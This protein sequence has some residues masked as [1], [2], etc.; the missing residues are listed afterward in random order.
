[1]ESE[2]LRMPDRPVLTPEIH[3]QQIDAFRKIR[4]QYEI[5]ARAL[6]RVL[7]HACRFSFPDALV[8]SRAKTVSSFAEKV[9]RKF[10]KYPN[11]VEQLKDFC[12]ARVIVQTLEQVR[13]VRSFIEA[14]FEILESE[15]KGLLLSTDKFGYRDMHYVVCLQTDRAIRLGFTEDEL[16]EIGTRCAE[17]QVR[18]WLEHAWADTL[19][20]RI[21]KNELKLSPDS[22]RT[23]ALLAALMEEGDRNFNVLA[24]DLDGLIAN[25]TALASKTEVQKEIEIQQLILDQELEEGKRPG[26]ALKLARLVGACGDHQRVVE[27]LKGYADTRDGN[28][29]DLLLELGRSICSLERGKPASPEYGRGVTFLREAARICE[30]PQ[31]ASVPH[32][33][34]RQSRHARAVALLG[35]AMTAINGGDPEARQ[36]FR[37]AHELEPAD[38]YYL[39]TMLGFELRFE[40]RSGLP[41]SMATT[42]QEAVRICREHAAAGIELPAAY[43]SAGR[44]SLLL[45][46]GYEALGYY[47]L[48]MRYCLSGINCV[49]ADALAEEKRWI[50]A[51]HPGVEVSQESRR[52]LDLFDLGERTPGDAN[53]PKQT[54]NWRHPV[55]ILTGGAVSLQHELIGKTKE[56][57]EKSCG[58][59]GGTI[60]S[61]GTTAGVPGCIGDVAREL[62]GK[63]HKQ[64]KLIGYRPALLPRAQAAHLSYDEIVEIG[65]NFLPDQ[66][67]RNWADLVDGGVRP[68][69]VLVLGIGGG[70]LSLVEYQVALTLGAQVGILNGTGGTADVLIADPLWSGLPNLYRL[71]FDHATVRAFVIRG[72]HDLPAD[73]QLQMAQFFHAKYVAGGSNRLPPNMR[74][75][76]KLERTYIEANREQAR[77]SVE[78][79]KAAGFDVIKSG[80]IEPV[81]PNFTAEEV[82][83]MAELEHGRWNV[84]RLRNGWRYGKVKDEPQR[85]HDCLVSWEELPAHIKTYDQE[86]V[87]VFPEALAQAGLA[88]RRRE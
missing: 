1:M 19:H 14:N 8:Q 82:E 56:L 85:I 72:D 64:F 3:R 83:C 25:Y 22:L 16:T 29:C 73:L 59:F 12:G 48:G 74:P 75:W 18:T 41:P 70:A 53:G 52:I 42:I 69:D 4:P 62:S 54:V 81:W 6:K 51:I 23:G 58:D 71:P 80:S 76:Q 35:W 31:V 30:D 2:R 79:L 78:I 63:G 43:F 38:P 60:V 67:L 39:S 33:R 44:L 66:I 37:R 24:D 10:D 15:D 13:G 68:A 20:D 49:Q 11:A 40:S 47:A 17:I 55:L 87:R 21:Y 9:V 46:Q 50:R 84:E 88:I 36:L 45:N 5:F 34:K 27:L 61:G 7:E 26:L 57:L 86:S 77:Y 28:R 65:D 32:L